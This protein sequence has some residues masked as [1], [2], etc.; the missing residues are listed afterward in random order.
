MTAMLERE[1]RQ[2]TRPAAPPVPRTPGRRRHSTSGASDTVALAVWVSLLVVTA[3][4]VPHGGLQAIFAS[5]PTSIGRLTGLYASNL[6][7]LQ[8]LGMSRIPSVERAVGQDRLTYWH[9]LSGMT[10]FYLMLAHVDR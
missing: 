8:V 7:L 6:L 5:G 2:T 4:W 1:V 10:S 9:R 3:L